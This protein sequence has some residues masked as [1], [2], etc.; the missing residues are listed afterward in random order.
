MTPPTIEV[1]LLTWKKC[2]CF[3]TLPK[4][5]R[6]VVRQGSRQGFLGLIKAERDLT[7]HVLGN[8]GPNSHPLGICSFPIAFHGEAVYSWPSG[9]DSEEVGVEGNICHNTQLKSILC[10][11][12]PK[13][14]HNRLGDLNKRHL[15]VVKVGS[16]WSPWSRCLKI[17]FLVR[18]LLLVAHSCLLAISSLS[19]PSVS[20]WRWL[21]SLFFFLCTRTIGL[22]LW[23]SWVHEFT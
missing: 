21:L 23:S 9:S 8:D 7:A 10:L 18:P 5:W 20:S 14:Q 13:T 1:L 3:C 22:G 15:P 16:P 17:R 11:R 4:K 12:L 19:L 6:G 2:A